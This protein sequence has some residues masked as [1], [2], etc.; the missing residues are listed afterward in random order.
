MILGCA[1]P[2]G[3]TGQNIARQAA[4]R[5]GL[6]VTTAGTVWPLCIEKVS[7]IQ[8]MVC[9]FVYMSGAG[10]SR[11]GPRMIEISEV[12]RRVM[13]SSSSCDSD[14]GSTVIPPLAPP[15]GMLTTAHFHVIHIASA[16]T[17]S[18]VTPGW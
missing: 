14:L 12:K 17:S 8:A 15:K 9:E 18:I 2:E 13:R 5:A 16:L 3:A 6:P 4:L 7:I 11:S 10:I 1:L